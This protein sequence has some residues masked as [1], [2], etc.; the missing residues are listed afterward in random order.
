M[1]R[2]IRVAVLLF[3]LLTVAVGS[4][5]ARVRTTSWN[6]ALDVV[7]FPINADGTSGTAAYIGSLGNEA[8][9]PIK[10]FMRDEAREYGIDLL[11]PV[12][13]YIGPEVEAMPPAPPVGGSVPSVI[14]WSL[15]MRFWAW[16]HGEHPV[17]RPDVRIYALLYHPSTMQRLDHSVGLQKG[18][19]GVA[20][21]F[22]VPHMTAENNIIITHELLHTLGATDKYDPASNQP[23][24]PAGYAQPDLSPLYP[25]EFAEIMAGRIPVADDESIA[26]QT[27]ESVL[28]GPETAREIGWL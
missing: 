25:Q 12:D 7:V 24:Y 27:L 5:Q 4:W 20:K 9:E 17:L 8:F 23:L 3:I 15:H 11:N 6:R 13:V 21:L 28:V 22:A 1:A 16:R 14:L 2:K 10:T 26:P 19:I 18:L